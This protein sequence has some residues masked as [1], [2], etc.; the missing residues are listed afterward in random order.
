MIPA[1]S[2]PS[3]SPRVSPVLSLRSVGL[4]GSSASGLRRPGLRLAELAHEQR[5]SQSV[6]HD[7]T[8]LRPA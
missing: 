8:A 7:E 3:Y 1:R 6:H 2:L 4:Q 5:V